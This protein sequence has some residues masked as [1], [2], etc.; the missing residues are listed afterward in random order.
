MCGSQPVY[1]PNSFSGPQAE[2]ERYAD[3]RWLVE[4]GEIMR[5]AY[6]LHA[7]DGDFGQA[8]TLYRKVLT[9]TEK[10]HL[11]SNVVGH[12]SQVTDRTVKDRA[13]SLWRKVDSE[14]GELI[15][16]G[17]GMPAPRAEPA[18]AGAI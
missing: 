18:A 17:L 14:L 12:M 7:E 3:P 4:S 10:D 1:A 8:G 6:T 11:V 2:P 15:A 5:T 13:L 9:T 16:A